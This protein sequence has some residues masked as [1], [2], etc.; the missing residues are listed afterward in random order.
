ML[1]NL[2]ENNIWVRKESNHKI[3]NESRIIQNRI[4]KIIEVPDENEIEIEIMNKLFDNKK[5]KK[6]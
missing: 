5:L 3:E 6:N 2:W 4:T 1:D